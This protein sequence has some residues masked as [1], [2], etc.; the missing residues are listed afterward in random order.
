MENGKINNEYVMDECSPYNVLQELELERKRIARELHDSTIQTLTILIYKAEYCEKI[1]EKDSIRTKME[2]QLMIDLLKESIADI[3]NSIYNLHPMSIE[4]LGLV[5]SIQRYLILLNRD[6]N[7]NF[8]LKV[9]GTEVQ[10]CP[11]VNVSL[12]RIV[13]ES[14]NN[15]IKH[16]KGTK[17][18]ISITYTDNNLYLTVQDN[19]IGLCKENNTLN[20][21]MDDYCNNIFNYNINNGYGLTMM[22]ER[23]NLLSGKFEIT[24]TK[25]GTI[26]KVCIPLSL[27]KEENNG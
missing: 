25:D 22:R 21:D 10:C 24:Y 13:Q 23:V 26:I 8:V 17:A 1:I 3:R 11:I 27:N 7:I 15:I 2:L 4:D 14:C 18:C 6:T 12:Y 5:D 20:K 9:E 16:S 19:G